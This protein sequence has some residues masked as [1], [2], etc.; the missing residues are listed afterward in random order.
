MQ[1]AAP[2][3]A[4]ELDARLIALWK[5][6]GRVQRHDLSRTAASVLAAAARQRPAAHHRARRR[7]GASRSRR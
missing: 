5:A 3:L 1:A 7:R 2:S 4:S 6:V